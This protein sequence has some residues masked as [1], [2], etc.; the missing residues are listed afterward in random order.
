MNS[1]SSIISFAGDSNAEKLYVALK[2]ILTLIAVWCV[3]QYFFPYYIPSIPIRAPNH[4]FFG[5]ANSIPSKKGKLDSHLLTLSE[6]E[7]TGKVFQYYNFGRLRVLIS[8]KYVA[9]YVLE[10]VNGKGFYHRGNEKI[11]HQNIF[12]LDTGPEWK[13]RRTAFRQSFSMTQLKSCQE[14]LKLLTAKLISS[15]R[16]SAEK[17]EAIGID[18]IFGQVTVD[19]ICSVGFQYDMH[20]MEDSQISQVH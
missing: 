10:K 6:V 19:V 7:K 9:K 14:Q 12:N 20:A 17:G 4:W 1:I 3:K 8:D 15:L 13:K 18:R 2:L 16:E 5:F 11:S